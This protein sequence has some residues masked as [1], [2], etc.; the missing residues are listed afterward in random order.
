MQSV[1]YQNLKQIH[2]ADVINGKT[3][4]VSFGLSSDYVTNL[5]KP[6]KANLFTL[7]SKTKANANNFRHSSENQ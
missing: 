4:A 5:K 6:F 3:C 2:V 1:N 7:S